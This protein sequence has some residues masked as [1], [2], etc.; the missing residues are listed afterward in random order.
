MLSNIIQYYLFNLINSFVAGHM[1]LGSKNKETVA[2]RNIH[3]HC[4]II[5]LKMTFNN[6][7]NNIQK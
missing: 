1:L 2:S 7:N 4:R 5:R 3:I 6:D